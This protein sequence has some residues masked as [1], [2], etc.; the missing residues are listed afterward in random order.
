V[1]DIF[2]EVVNIFR[3]LERVYMKIERVLFGNF[4]NLRNLVIQFD[5]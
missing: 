4:W 2:T 5:V 3:E 1:S